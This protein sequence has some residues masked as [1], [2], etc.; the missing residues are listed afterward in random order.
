MLRI[1]VE[2]LILLLLPSVLYFTYIYLTA[3]KGASRQTAINDAPFVWL[4]AAGVALALG[5]L[6]LFATTSG[7]KPGDVYQPP[8]F[9]D[10]QIVPGELSRTPTDDANAK[11]P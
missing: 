6:A 10:G 8:T 9:R 5:V 7:S 4:F 1:V 3:K 11:T 2:N